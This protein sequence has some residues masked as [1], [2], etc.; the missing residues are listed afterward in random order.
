MGGWG[1]YALTGVAH[2]GGI[3]SR[4]FTQRVLPF[5]QDEFRIRYG[6]KSYVYADPVEKRL[7]AATGSSTLFRLEQKYSAGCD[8][9]GLEYEVDINNRVDTCDFPYLDCVARCGK[10]VLSAYVDGKF[11]RISRGK[12]GRR[13]H[14]TWDNIQNTWT[15]YEL[16]LPL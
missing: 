5:L 1:L 15:A 7:V 13:D 4:V 16:E 9:N 2:T 14:V 3:A 10:R 12:G 6:S 11:K 8:P